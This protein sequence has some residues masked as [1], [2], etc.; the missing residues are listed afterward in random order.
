MDRH[1]MLRP[2]V[3]QQRKEKISVPEPGPRDV[4]GKLVSLRRLR[5]RFTSNLVIDQSD[6]SLKRSTVI[7]HGMIALVSQQELRNRRR[8][9]GGFHRNLE[10][11]RISGTGKG[12]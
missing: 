11:N 7:W 2:V 1:F 9:G 8:A 5:R 4:A 12:E 3:R 10:L 6:K